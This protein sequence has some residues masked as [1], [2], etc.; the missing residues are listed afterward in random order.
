MLGIKP[1]SSERVASVKP[2][3]QPQLFIWLLGLE[4]GSSGFH[5]KHF[6]NGTISPAPS[7]LPSPSSV[8]SGLQKLRVTVGVN[9]TQGL[10]LVVYC[11]CHTSLVFVVVTQ[12]SSSREL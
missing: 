2:C 8:L 4:L 12:L 10:G 9:G 11:H 6:T 3:P 7:F 5:G 1:R